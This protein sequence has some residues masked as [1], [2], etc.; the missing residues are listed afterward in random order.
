MSIIVGCTYYEND[1]K[2][3]VVSLIAA[4]LVSWFY[5]WPRAILNS[6]RENSHS[7]CA[8]FRRISIGKLFDVDVQFEQKN[9]KN[10]GFYCIFVIREEPFSLL[11]L[12]SS[13]TSISVSWCEIFIIKYVCRFLGG[14]I[15]KKRKIDARVE[16]THWGR[17]YICQT[18]RDACMTKSGLAPGGRSWFDWE[19]LKWYLSR[20]LRYRYNTLKDSHPRFC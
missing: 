9:L 2:A 1:S 7:C 4:M 19:G 10:S 14:G 15:I 8:L 18:R 3:G 16:E 20:V 17:R 6:Q 11:T 12:F 5:C 13:V